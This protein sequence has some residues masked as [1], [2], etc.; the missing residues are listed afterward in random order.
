MTPLLEQAHNLTST[1]Y[2]T[3]Q[4]VKRSNQLNFRKTDAHQNLK[5]TLNMTP[6]VLERAQNLML[7]N[8]IHEA[9]S[10]AVTPKI[11]LLK[12]EKRFMKVAQ[13]RSIS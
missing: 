11:K 5:P 10:V 3:P 9:K 8:Y 13:N 12:S 4:V 1:P 2:M 6:Q 7:A